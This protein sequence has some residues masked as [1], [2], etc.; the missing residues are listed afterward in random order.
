MAV[1]RETVFADMLKEECFISGKR[2][3]PVPIEVVDR[4]LPVYEP[5]EPKED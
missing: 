5:P 3:D 1:F 2:P 4:E